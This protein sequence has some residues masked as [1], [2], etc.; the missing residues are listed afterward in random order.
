MLDSRKTMVRPAGSPNLAQLAPFQA[1][2]GFVGFK[3]YAVAILYLDS[4]PD[5]V[6]E[7]IENSIWLLHVAFLGGGG[8]ILFLSM[9]E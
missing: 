1:L 6:R 4:K 3:I 7:K 5:G 8:R 9:E 2:G